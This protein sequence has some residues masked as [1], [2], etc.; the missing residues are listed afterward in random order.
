ME[1]P[2]DADVRCEEG[3]QEGDQEGRQEDREEGHQEGGEE[4]V[5]GTAS[6]WTGQDQAAAL[7]TSG[8]AAHFIADL[9]R[10][11]ES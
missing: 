11:V 6:S 1:G 8:A 5:T 4:E 3:R 7:A 9:A 10:A 2:Y